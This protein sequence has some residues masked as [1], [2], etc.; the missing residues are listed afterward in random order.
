[1]ITALSNF[2][3][4]MK[5]AL[6][7]IKQHSTAQNDDLAVLKQIEVSSFDL[8]DSRPLNMLAI[9]GSH[10]FILNFSTRWLAVIKIAALLYEFVEGEKTGFRLKDVFLLEKPEVISTDAEQ[11]GEIETPKENSHLNI[12][13]ELRRYYEHEVLSQLS[14]KLSNTLIAM[15]GALTTP[16]LPKFQQKMASTLKSCKENGNIVTGISKDSQTRAFGARISDEELLSLHQ[17]R[18]L[19]YAKVPS[20]FM[21]RYKPPLY[22]DIYFAR[23]FPY[24]KRWFRVDIAGNAEEAFPQLAA[25]SRSQLCPGYPYPLLEAHRFAVSVRHFKQRYEELLLNLAS[26]QGIDVERIAEWRTNI[27]GKRLSS[28][29]EFLDEVARGV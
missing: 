25:Y 12:A 27:D 14:S 13:N 5:K 10:S 7:T 28:F 19:G 6:E 23:L 2:E 1:M 29:H 24:A 26:S 3:E 4:E 11:T 22:G 20:Q 16:F 15:D 18:G 9:D 21:E 17:H 8:P